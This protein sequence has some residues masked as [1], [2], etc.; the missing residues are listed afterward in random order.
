MSTITK[1]SLNVIQYYKNITSPIGANVRIQRNIQLKI[2]QNML[3]NYKRKTRETSRGLE[4]WALDGLPMIH[5][6]AVHLWLTSGRIYKL[7]VSRAGHED[8]GESEL[9]NEWYGECYVACMNKH[10][11]ID[12]SESNSMHW[13]SCHEHSR[14]GAGN[15]TS[16]E[17]NMAEPVIQA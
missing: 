12:K 13:K 15:E 4:G 2:V 1:F 11:C 8:P 10:S 9:P 17:V 7:R 6:S 5:A 3:M 16:S 14:T